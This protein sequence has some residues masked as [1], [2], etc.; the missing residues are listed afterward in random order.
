MCSWNLV[1]V[2]VMKMILEVVMLMVMMM[3]MMR[4]MTMM[5][6]MKTM[7]MVILMLSRRSLQ[8]EPWVVERWRTI[9]GGNCH[10]PGWDFVG[11]RQAKT[12]QEMQ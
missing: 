1:L 6:V 3:T 12:F 9:R 7:M 8:L 2:E 10:P 5:M 4:M 11:T